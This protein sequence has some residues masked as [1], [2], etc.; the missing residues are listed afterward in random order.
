MSGSDQSTLPANPGQGSGAMSQ[1]I[2]DTWLPLLHV[3]Q[4]LTYC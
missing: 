4:R 1:L 3:R 2:L